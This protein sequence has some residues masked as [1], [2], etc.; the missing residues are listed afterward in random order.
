MAK[1]ADEEQALAGALGGGLKA[2]EVDAVFD[3]HAARGRTEQVRVFFRHYDDPPEARDGA[4]LEANPAVVVPPGGE[5][6]LTAGDLAEQVEGD[7]VLDQKIAAVFRQLRVFHLQAFKAEDA[8]FLVER[9]PHSRR[10]V[11][12]HF[13]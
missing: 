8:P 1:R 11:L 10:T 9:A 12:A 2:I 5:R 3:H 4:A 6:A 7:V 13:R